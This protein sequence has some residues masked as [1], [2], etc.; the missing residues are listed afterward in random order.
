MI[1][2]IIKLIKKFNQDVKIKIR[3]EEEKLKLIQDLNS[4]IVNLANFVEK[5]SV[6]EDEIFINIFNDLSNCVNDNI[7]IK[8]V[9]N[10]SRLKVSQGL[11]LQGILSL[12]QIKD[13]INKV[14]KSTFILDNWQREAIISNFFKTY[15]KYLP[16]ALNHIENSNLFDNNPFETKL[17]IYS[18]KIPNGTYIKYDELISIIKF[19]GKNFYKIIDDKISDE[20]YIPF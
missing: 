17:S 7:I 16:M 6:V 4:N 12:K 19:A 10:H 3:E 15:D 14:K 8:E 2:S 1:Y 20:V 9:C 18:K 13:E 11:F 5:Q